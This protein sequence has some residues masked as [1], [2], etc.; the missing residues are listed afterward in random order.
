MNESLDWPGYL[1]DFHQANPGITEE[2]LTRCLDTE[3][4]NPYEWLV[5]GI[6]SRSRVLDLACGSAPTRPLLGRAWIGIDQAPAEL[7][8][9][10]LT[11]HAEVVRAD[12][13]RLPIRS[14]SVD[15]VVCSMALMLIDDLTAALSEVRRVLTPGGE[16]R[17]TVPTVRPLKVRD[18]LGY[19]RL[20]VTARAMPRFPATPLDSG[21]DTIRENGLPITSDETRRFT[22]LLEDP[23]AIDLFVDSWYTS[24]APVARERTLPARSL[25]G[26]RRTI[27]VGLRRIIARRVPTVDAASPSLP[28]TSERPDTRTGFL[29]GKML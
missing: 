15:V 13:T 28:N 3:G 8:R 11:H 16:L 19:L 23:E 29:P 21:L 6:G 4:R 10:R 7:Q 17:A 18:R 2:V 26:R 24:R 12:A 25:R 20:A 22:Y 9:A 5:E 1:A 27:G 14:G